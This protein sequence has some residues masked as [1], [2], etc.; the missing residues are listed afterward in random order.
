MIY[1]SWGTPHNRCDV[2]CY[3]D[4]DQ[5]EEGAWC[6]HIAES[7]QVGDFAR[8]NW[9]ASD[10][11]IAGAIEDIESSPIG[12]AYDGQTFRE[13]NIHDFRRRLHDLKV[14]G[15]RFPHHVFDIIDNEAPEHA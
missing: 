14:I 10:G 12:L 2:Y 11:D 15:Y 3:H 6:I 1:C 9:S 8:I 4:I 5:A 13:Y 7:K